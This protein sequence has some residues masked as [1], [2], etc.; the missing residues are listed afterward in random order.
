MSL[1]N[2]LFYA[3]YQEHER[4]AGLWY[5]EWEIVENITELTLGSLAKSIQLID[6]LEIHLER[7]MENLEALFSA[8]ESIRRSEEIVSEILENYAS[9]ENQ[10]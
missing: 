3:D 6:N 5:S 2:G 7:M 8:D 1:F 10:L 9:Y 4:S